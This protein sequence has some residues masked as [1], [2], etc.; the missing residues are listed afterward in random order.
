VKDDKL[1]DENK[2]L[3]EVINIVEIERN[4]LLQTLSQ[5]KG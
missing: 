3:K 2:K 1:L 4:S 5:M